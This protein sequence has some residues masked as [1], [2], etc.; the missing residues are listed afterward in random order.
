[1][2]Q[3]LHREFKVL[4]NSL[5]VDNALCSTGLVFILIGSYR[6]IIMLGL[7]NNPF[8]AVFY[9]FLGFSLVLTYSRQLRVKFIKL[10]SPSTLNILYEKSFIELLTQPSPYVRALIVIG[11][12][13]FLEEKELLD[14]ISALPPS[15]DVFKRKGLIH[16]FPKAVHSLH[17]ED[18]T[19]ID[20]I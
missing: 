8:G 5:S 19:L 7:P 18:N 13:V 9:I 11:I 1:M 12:S 14:L 6:F 15:C 4:S 2:S 17:I 16:L 10:L 20:I 3:N